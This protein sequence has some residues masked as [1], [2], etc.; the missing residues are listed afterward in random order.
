MTFV[1]EAPPPARFTAALPRLLTGPVDTAGCRHT[2]LTVLAIPAR[3]TPEGSEREE[4]LAHLGH[5]TTS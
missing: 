3:V 2:T 5:M 4:S 1:T